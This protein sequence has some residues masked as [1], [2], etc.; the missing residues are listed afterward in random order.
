[1]IIDHKAE[2]TKILQEAEYVYMNTAQLRSIIMS[3]RNQINLEGRGT[4]KSYKIGWVIN[5]INRIMP[6]AITGVSGTTFGQLLTRTLPSTFKFLQSLGYKQHNS[7]K[8]PGNYVIGQKPPP[9]FYRPYEEIMKYDHTISFSNGNSIALFSQDRVGSSRGPNVDYLILDEAL[10]INKKRY[11]E[12]TSPTNRGNEDKW[13]FLSKN[14]VPMHHGFHYVSSMPYSADQKWLLDYG[15]YYEEEKGIRIFEIWNRIVSVQMQ[16]IDAKKQ[17]NLNLFRDLL[18]ETVRLRRQITPF[19]SQ[20]GTLFTLANAIDNVRN[21]GFSYIMREYE[22]LPLITFLVEIMNMILDVVEDC[23]YS[24]DNK[25]HVYY[26][27]YNDSFLRDYAE[28]TNW[29]FQKLGTPDSRF[30]MDCDPT[31]PLEISPDWGAKIALFTIGQERNFDFV[32]RLAIPTDNF[33]NEFF[34]KPD[35]SPGVMINTLVDD[36]CNYYQHQQ[37]REIIYYHDKYGDHKQPNAK[38]SETYNQQAIARFNKNKWRV[39]SKH[40]KGMEPPQHEK[41]LL[42]AN[43]LKKENE[44]VIFPN[45]RFNGNKCKYTLISM[46]STRVIDKNG[47]FEKD[48]SSERRNSV[49]PEEATHFGDAADKRIW[50]KY[51]HLLNKRFSIFVPARI[52][53]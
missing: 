3:P 12:E 39:V 24:I 26:D 29:D 42:W 46:N 11:N 5:T 52:G 53:S 35:Q 30:D 17:S 2:E 18:N 19:V 41:F 23:Y 28:N 51:Y 36:F 44:D 21:V 15:K 37:C 47:K 16:L 13:G 33:I 22:N 27:S 38:N 43:I 25:K 7:K 4:G 32:S 31:K 10:T 14:P 48:K 45:I 50:T 9:H 6:R 1:M 40:H 20:D 49:L 8:D 34:I